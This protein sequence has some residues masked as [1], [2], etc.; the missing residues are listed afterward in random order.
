MYIAFGVDVR[1]LH[2]RNVKT[3]SNLGLN[4]PRK[5]CWKIR[6]NNFFFSHSPFYDLNMRYVIRTRTY[7]R[8]ARYFLDKWSW[9]RLRLKLDKAKKTINLMIECTEQRFLA[10]FVCHTMNRVVF[11]SSYSSRSGRCR[12][13]TARHGNVWLH[14][15]MA[16][17]VIPQFSSFDEGCSNQGRSVKLLL[18]K[19]FS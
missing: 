2:G 7:L 5:S 9:T 1:S 12:L 6:V 13:V 11:R 10:I 15:W 8:P 14:L 19:L 16:Y 18:M 17:K 3:F 4:R